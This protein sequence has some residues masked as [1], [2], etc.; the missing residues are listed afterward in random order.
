MEKISFFLGQTSLTNDLLS[1]H[2]RLLY[3]CLAIFSYSTYR[4]YEGK[5][6][7]INSMSEYKISAEIAA[8]Y[9]IFGA[10]WHFYYAQFESCFIFAVFLSLG[11]ML[12]QICREGW[13]KE[14]LILYGIQIESQ[15]YNICLDLQ[16]WDNDKKMYQSG[17]LNYSYLFENNKFTCSITVPI[18]VYHTYAVNEPVLIKISLRY[19]KVNEF[20]KPINENRQ[21]RAEN[22]EKSQIFVIEDVY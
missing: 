2:S 9:L 21:I 14:E 11:K 4:Y 3:V 1:P 16:T 20:I 15:I 22:V 18:E 17:I 12:Q 13:H 5:S 7:D 10:L 8:Y 19:P 6:E